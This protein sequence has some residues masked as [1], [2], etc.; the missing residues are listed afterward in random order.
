M[1]HDIPTAFQAR[2]QT[3]NAEEIESENQLN[4]LAQSIKSAISSKL[5]SIMVKET[6][7][8]SVTMKELK[9][10]GYIIQR[11]NSRNINYIRISW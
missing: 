10:L 7:V 9:K 4:S 3:Y 5:S 11:E 8:N 1:K 2:M 6:E